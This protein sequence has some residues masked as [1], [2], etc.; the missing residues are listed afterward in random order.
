MSHWALP[1]APPLHRCLHLARSPHGH[2]ACT[3]DS[4]LCPLCPR[5]EPAVELI[6][7]STPEAPRIARAEDYVR[8]VM[9]E[10]WHRLLKAPLQE[11]MV[12]A[13]LQR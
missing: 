9:P 1:A 12:L 7:E 4:L 11:P 2:A 10:L 3:T 13:D 8:S 5:Y 6:I